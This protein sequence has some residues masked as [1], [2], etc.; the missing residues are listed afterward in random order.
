[1]KDIVNFNGMGREECELERNNRELTAWNEW[2]SICWIL[3]CSPENR[4]I[5]KKLVKNKYNELIRNRLGFSIN[6]TDEDIAN[7]FDNAIREAK[8][9]PRIDRRTKTG[10]GEYRRRKKKYWKNTVWEAVSE[11][12]DPPLKIIR[13]KILG[14][15]GFINEIV[16]DFLETEYN[17]TVKRIEGGGRLY[18]PL[19]SINETESSGD[20]DNE[21]DLEDFLA[22]KL[23]PPISDAV[24]GEIQSAL[25]KQ[26]G[27]RDAIIL[28]SKFQGK[29]LN[30]PKILTLLGVGKS[31]ASEIWDDTKRKLEKLLSESVDECDGDQLKAALSI[32]DNWLS[33][34]FKSE[35]KAIDSL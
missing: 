16:A 4:E 31:Q 30:N 12:N 1:M 7:D 18:M 14:E 28:I 9:S 3:G 6:E 8:D 29:P 10:D 17:C 5:L 23:S 19:K 35:Y 21:H 33:C 20:S 26:I 15:K 34:N 32:V 25:K 22:S 11:S 13:G 27:G 2:K 24:G